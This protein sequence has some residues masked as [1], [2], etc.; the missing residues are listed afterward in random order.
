MLEG[1]P[2]AP[3]SQRRAVL[4][5]LSHYSFRMFYDDADASI[6]VMFLAP[7][8]PCRK[9]HYL[10]CSTGPTIQA[11]AVR[12]V[13]EHTE[14]AGHGVLLREPEPGEQAGGTRA[15]SSSTR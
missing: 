8:V 4:R 11:L 3:S 2:K 1:G 12:I 7:G 5:A 15:G 13:P 10:E 6:S 14:P 9:P